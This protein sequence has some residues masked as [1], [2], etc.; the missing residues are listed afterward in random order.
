MSWERLGDA[1]RDRRTTLGMTQGEVSDRG[2]PS[3]ETVRA[4]E[5]NRAGRLSPRMRRAL[6]RALEWGAGS[7][8]AVIAGGAAT[9]VQT[10]PDT[11]SAVD[12]FAL[13]RQVVSLKATLIK[14]LDGMAD[15]TRRAL[16][17]EVTRSAREAEE[18]IITVMPRLDDNERGQ[19]IELL[20]TLRDPIE[21]AEE[22]RPTS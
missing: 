11:A 15:D 9:V 7:I 13:A 8:D 12:R 5:N 10:K 14:H 22:P 16:V 18:S 21:S 19:A 2:G 17:G 1:V 3:V 20:V 4:I 6:E